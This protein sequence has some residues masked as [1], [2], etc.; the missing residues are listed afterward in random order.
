LHGNL[1]R[2]HVLP[3][4]VDARRIDDRHFHVGRQREH[5]GLE[6][7][8]F[9]LAVPQIDFDRREPVLDQTIDGAHRAAQGDVN[10]RRDAGHQLA[11]R[12]LRGA[13]DHRNRDRAHLLFLLAVQVDE[14]TQRES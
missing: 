13:N 14:E 2:H 8:L 4:E 12:V 10:A 1:A 5:T 6:R 7:D 9:G 3:V 11:L